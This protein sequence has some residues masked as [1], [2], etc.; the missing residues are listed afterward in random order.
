MQKQG[1]SMK[2]PKFLS[3][4]AAIP[5]DPAKTQML[6]LKRTLQPKQA[7]TMVKPRKLKGSV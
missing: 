3:R 1:V 5:K 4:F 7:H 2:A 6:A